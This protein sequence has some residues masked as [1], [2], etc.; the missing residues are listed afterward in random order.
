MPLSEMNQ[1]FLSFGEKRS[2]LA[3]VCENSSIDILRYLVEKNLAIG[4]AMG[5]M[6]FQIQ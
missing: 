6:Y 2:I 5:I 4:I 1:C 3:T